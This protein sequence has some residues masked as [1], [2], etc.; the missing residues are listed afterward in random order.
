MRIFLLCWMLILAPA[1]CGAP[2][3]GPPPPVSGAIL[4]RDL[5]GCYALTTTKRLYFAPP[6]LRLDSTAAVDQMRGFVRDSAWA[7]ARL[8]REGRPM[9]DEQQHPILYWTAA[10]ADSILIV[11]STGFSGSELVVGAGTGDTL[12]GRATE[13]W[14]MGPSKNDAGAVTL[15][16][17]PCVTPG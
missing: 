4:P 12:Q 7:L 1:A 11:I 16:R 6:Q 15:V 5:A 8:D 10:P 13:F 2:A 9:V 17:I 14:D 3:A